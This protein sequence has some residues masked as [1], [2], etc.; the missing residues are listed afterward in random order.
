MAQA[1]QAT[2]VDR[3]ARRLWGAPVALSTAIAAGTGIVAD[4][5]AATRLWVNEEA[6]VKWSENVADD[7]VRNYVRLR[8]EGRFGFGV[9][10]PLA[11][12]EVDLTAA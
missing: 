12:V 9:L 11:V 5:E 7:F 1:G 3:A 10:R 6:Q 2:P 8:V 4:F